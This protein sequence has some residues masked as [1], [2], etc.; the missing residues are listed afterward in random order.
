[1][2]KPLRT[3]FCMLLSFSIT[4]T[5]YASV[6]ISI[7]ESTYL[8]TTP[9]RLS[10]VL[11]PV[12]L[13]KH[14]SWPASQLF[15]LDAAA[16]EQ[17]RSQ[18]IE[19]LAKEGRDNT[20]YKSTFQSIINQLKSWQIAHRVAIPIDFELA[21]YSLPNNPQFEAGSY[22]LLLSERPT[23]LYV[24]GAVSTP[25]NITYVNNQCLE[26]IMQTIVSAPFA[27]SS[28]V[29]IISPQGKVQ[30]APIAYWNRQC[31]L[32]MP[33]STLYVPLRENTLFKAISNVNEDIATFAV[34]RIKSQ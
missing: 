23:S 33:G 8:F 17:E 21:R 2:S 13:Q 3:I 29:Y 28:F 25:S 32:P 26:D 14:W 15:S 24:F 20:K 4:P 10:D 19:L 22:Q 30:K 11:A 7:N 9:P 12:A 27:D 31:I 6:E 5:V 34:N 18:L 1:M 16:V